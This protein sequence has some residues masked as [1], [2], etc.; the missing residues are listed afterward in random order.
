MGFRVEKVLILL[1]VFVSFGSSAL[2][3]QPH[4]TASAIE[5]IDRIQSEVT[6]D[7]D[8]GKGFAEVE[9][10]MKVEQGD[11]MSKYRAQQKHIQQ[12]QTANSAFSRIEK[13]M[14]TEN[15]NIEHNQE[16][17]LAVVENTNKQIKDMIKEVMMFSHPK[18]NS[19]V[20]LERTN[21]V[22]GH[23]SSW[24]DCERSCHHSRTRSILVN[25]SHG[26]KSCPTMWETDM[27]T[28]GGCRMF[29]TDEG[30]DQHTQL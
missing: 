5:A 13:I 20:N 27:C 22:M 23:C 4:T 18:V 7:A 10:M 11:P 1:A 6:Q 3:Q 19:N 24:G 26:G 14:H 29:K 16:K 15:R 2:S 21:C 9:N 28:G 17:E 25:P 30:S 8:A 12:K